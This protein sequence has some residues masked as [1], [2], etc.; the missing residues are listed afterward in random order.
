MTMR[1]S[2]KWTL[3]ALAAAFALAMVGCGGGDEDT[4]AVMSPDERTAEGAPATADDLA[5][6]WL[7]EEGIE[8]PLL[9]RF[10]PDGSFA[11]DWVGRLAATPAA[12]GTYEVDEG[13]V[14]LAN[15]KSDVCAR[16]DS[17]AWDAGI[18]EEGRVDVIWTASEARDEECDPG[19]G[20]RYTFI[21]VSP[22]SAPGAELTGTRGAE[23]RPPED[24]A[25]LAGIWLLEGS[26]QLLHF[27]ADGTYELDDV[28]ALGVDPDDAGTFELD[29]RGSLTFTSGPSSR[30]CTKGDRWVWEGVEIAVGP[31]R[32][33]DPEAGEGGFARGGDWT[34]TAD[35]AEDACDHSIGANAVWLRI[36]W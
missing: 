2:M 12:A 7:I 21:R 28:G 8:D 9:F 36:G 17:W 34:L 22:R 27:G 16:G 33:P 32:R 13:T 1:G 6:I 30:S 23:G 24:A 15:G 5:G 25:T 31:A 18:P 26:G 14:T 20:T 3:V 11:A 19:V 35:V 29:R 4:E 10:D